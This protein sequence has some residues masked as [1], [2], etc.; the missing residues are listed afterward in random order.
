ML[1][2]GVTGYG[3]VL[4][5]GM[6][7][8]PDLALTQALVETI[9]LVV[10][11][12]V[13]RRLPAADRAAQ[14]R[15]CTGR[16]RG[17]IGALAGI[18]MGVIGLVALGAR[19]A[20]DRSPTGSRRSPI[21][22]HGKN[23][24]NVM[25]VDIRAW[26][27]LGEISVLVAVA[28]GVASLIFVSAARAAPAP[29]RRRR[30]RE[31]ARPAAPGARARGQ[32][33]ARRTSLADTEARRMP[34]ARPPP[35]GRRGCSPAARSRRATARS[36]SRCSC[37]CCSTRR[38]SCSVYL[39]FVGH[40]APGGG[41][42]GGL[43]AG[44]ALVARYLAGGRYELGE[45][46]PVDAGR[47]L[48][49]GLLLAAGTAAALAALRRRAVLES[50]W[51]EADVPVLGTIS[52]GTVDALRHR[53]LPRGRRPGARHPP[54][55]R[56]RGRPAGGAR[57]RRGRGGGDLDRG[58]AARPLEQGEGP[59]IAERPEH[60]DAELATPA[61]R[62]DP[63]GGPPVTASLT[64]VVLMAVL[65]G[66][67]VSIMLERSLTRVLIGFLLVGNAVNLL[68]YL[69]SG[70]PGLAPILGEGVDP[71]EIS[72]PLPQAFVLTAIVINLGITA[73]MLALIYRSWWLAQLGAKGDLVDDEAEDAR[74]TPRRR[75]TSSAARRPTTPPIQ[76]IIE[77]SDEEPDEELEAEHP[78]VTPATATT[79]GASMT[80]ALVPLVVLLPLL[81][82][83]AA[84]DPR[85]PPPR[86]DG[87]EHVRARRGRRDRRACCSSSVDSGEPVVV[88]GRRL[89][90]PVRHRARRRPARRRSCC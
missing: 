53:R 61:D 11:V 76:E 48:G 5:F 39:L 81:G 82:A 33:R 62:R 51:F 34:R 80:A 31:P 38:S 24:V 3:L 73:F 25:L 18:V 78:L 63:R 4:L 37:A 65:F 17:I 19:I 15:R 77:A 46:A 79:G 47:L 54:L 70:T 83:A 12:L 71:D 8:A 55:A 85:P 22:A 1:L 74:R 68:I 13:L 72:D 36:S 28:T 20:A 44:L 27:T 45:A 42:A 16:P 60:A 87:R 6:S 30:A 57:R 23:I 40:N 64:L 2:V 88:D 49:T 35:R 32:I 89:G 66:A 7:G 9:T 21:E 58:A 52:I 50:A 29:R 26:D 41:F 69:M 67:G 56:R 90:G 59:E 75:P 86:A 43:L 84:L 10:F 14:R